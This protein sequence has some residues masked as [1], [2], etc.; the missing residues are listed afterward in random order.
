MMFGEKQ[1]AAVGLEWVRLHDRLEEDGYA[2][3]WHE[4]GDCPALPAHVSA[5]PQCLGLCLN[6][7]GQGQVALAGRPG[8]RLPPRQGLVFLCGTADLRVTRDA[9]QRHR[10]LIAF[11]TVTFVRDHLH[12]FAGQVHPFMRGLLSGR[13]PAAAIAD[14]QPLASHHLSLVAS[15]RRPPVAAAAQE[16]WYRS[17]AVELLAGFLF[18]PAADE[19]LFCSRRR[20]VAD[21]RTARV[22][23]LVRDRLAE[24]LA[25]EELARAAGCSP[26]HLSRTFSATMG[27]TIAQYLRQVRLEKAAELLRHGRHNVTETALEVGYSSLSHFSQAF[28]EAYGC[29]PGSYPQAADKK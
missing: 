7:E 18:A 8:V 25:L 4:S 2:F 10:F 1:P 13:T 24:P 3:D 11:F 6:L 26:H 28:Q 19:S 14:P 20:R 16:L 23:A 22:A 15:L 29:P 5:R 27:C 9:H 21:D 12:P 17:K